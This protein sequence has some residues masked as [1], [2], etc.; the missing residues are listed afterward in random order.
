MSPRLCAILLRLWLLCV[1]EYPT[2]SAGLWFGFFDYKA[3]EI[4]LPLTT[5]VGTFETP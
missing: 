2:K 5:A 3:G 4:Y 1:I